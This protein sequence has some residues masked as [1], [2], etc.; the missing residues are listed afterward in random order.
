MDTFVFLKPLISVYYIF[1]VKKSL[2]FSDITKDYYFNHIQ[3]LFKISSITIFHLERGL[4][5]WGSKSK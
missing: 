2:S 4:K 1:D 3:V 5:Y